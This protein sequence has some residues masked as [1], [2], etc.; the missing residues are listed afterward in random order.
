MK[1]YKKYIIYAVITLVFSFFGAALVCS[2]A[3]KNFGST[4][5][6]FSAVGSLAAILFAYF[7][8]SEQRYE[9]EED[10][11]QLKLSKRSFF[12]ISTGNIL[13]KSDETF[14]LAAEQIKR[15]QSKHYFTFDKENNRFLLINDKNYKFFFR[16]KNV[17]NYAAINPTLAITYKYAGLERKDT[18]HADTIVQSGKEAKFLTNVVIGD[19]KI[20]PDKKIDLNRA[21]KEIELYFMSSD[22]Y[23][24]KQKFKQRKQMIFLNDDTL[25]DQTTY[26][27]ENIEE[28]KKNE[29]PKYPTAIVIKVVDKKGD[30]PE[31]VPINKLNSW[32]I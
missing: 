8:N 29:F 27:S 15:K 14:F 23:Y 3:K 4:A 9:Y 30:S 19:K 16:I 1:K 22:G 20:N 32:L 5:D 17:S 12:A 6:W 2:T 24:Y 26:E 11:R 10:K 21:D 28:I 25:P 18:I 13:N 31:I 7:Q